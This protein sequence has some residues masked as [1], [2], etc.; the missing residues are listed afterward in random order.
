MK[1]IYCPHCKDVRR[2]TFEKRECECGASFGYYYKDGL[3]AVIGG[4]AIPLGID[5]FTFGYALEHRPETGMGMTFSAFVIPKQCPSI[6]D[7]NRG[8]L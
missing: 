2:L 7:K 1:L 4:D 3:H 6:I 8:E 5:N